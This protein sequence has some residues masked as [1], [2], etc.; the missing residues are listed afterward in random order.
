MLAL[1]REHRLEH[2]TKHIALRYFL[3][4]ELQQRGQLRLAYVA[5]EANTADIFTKALPPG[6]HQRFCTMLGFPTLSNVGG[7]T[8]NVQQAPTAPVAQTSDASP[9][10]TASRP[11]NVDANGGN[12]TDDDLPE[13]SVPVF[14]TPANTRQPVLDRDASAPE[15][16]GVQ[17]KAVRCDRTISDK[18]A[19][20]ETMRK[21][22]LTVRETARRAGVQPSAI[23]R[24]KKEEA[25]YKDAYDCRRRLH[26]AGRS[27]YPDMEVSVFRTFLMR[28]SKRLPSFKTC[29]LSN[30]LDGSED[31]LCL[32]HLIEGSEVEISDEVDPTG[33]AG[34]NGTMSRPPYHTE[35][36]MEDEEVLEGE[37]AEEDPDEGVEYWFAG[38][39]ENDDAAAY[40]PFGDGEECSV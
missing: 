38:E 32:R 30:A 25:H 13:V 33:W 36:T 34:E 22:L 28:R 35:A 27:L 4:R 24:W 1:C 23:R 29:G 5:S 3:A 14:P 31:N 40:D 10:N 16:C 17:T 7:V 21:E 19:W 8:I 26:G 6:D 12:V 9:S 20:L 2:R 39:D 37:V 11:S 18:L 15:A